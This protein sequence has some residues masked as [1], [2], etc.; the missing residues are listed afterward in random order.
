MVRFT[1]DNR[2]RLIFYG[3][4][5]GYVKADTAVVDEMFR[6]D[7]LNQ[8]LS[9]M[10]LTPRWEDGI[11]DRL[12][13]GE[14]TGEELAQSRKGCRIWQLKKDV[15]VAMRFIG[16]EDQVRKFGEPDAGNY[17]LVFDGDLGTSDLYDDSGS[18]FYYCDRVGFQPIR[19]EQKQ[20]PCIN[21]TL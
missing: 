14:V 6:T 11:F 16:Y 3:N 4:P 12:V 10:N 20:D 1:V 17:T 13:S 2:N 9:R 5:V 8:Y 19:F 15:D 18:E 7:E 21:M